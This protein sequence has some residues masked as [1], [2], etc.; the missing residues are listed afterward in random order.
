MCLTQPIWLQSLEHLVTKEVDGHNVSE[1]V[2]AYN[3]K[4]SEMPNAIIAET[5]KGKGVSFMENKYNWHYTV[6]PEG[7]YKKAMAELNKE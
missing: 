4:S 3:N 2:E 7:K 5:V 6:L 1:L